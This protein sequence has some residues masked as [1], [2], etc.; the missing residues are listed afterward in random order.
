MVR[1]RNN[2]LLHTIL[3][4]NWSRPP[5]NAKVNMLVIVTFDHS[6]VS[7]LLKLFVQKKIQER[8]NNLFIQIN[9]VNDH[10]SRQKKSFG[11]FRTSVNG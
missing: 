6:L 9:I 1:I 10:S 11:Y 5:V 4:P 8:A 3:V 2:V 7:Y